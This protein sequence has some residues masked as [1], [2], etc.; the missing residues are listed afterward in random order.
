M[1]TQ[2]PLG[3]PGAQNVKIWM[4]GALAGLQLAPAHSEASLRQDLSQG[5]LVGLTDRC[6]WGR[7]AGVV[8]WW[9]A[10]EWLGR[11]AGAWGCEPGHAGDETFPV[12]LP[13]S[14]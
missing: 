2:N 12:A 8:G 11:R 13:G 1:I 10:R 9:R 3:L 7:G 14:L 5:F 4:A 6:G